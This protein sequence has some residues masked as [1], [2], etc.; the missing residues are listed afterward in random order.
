MKYFVN[1]ILHN[2]ETDGFDYQ[3]PA[4]FDNLDSAKKEFHN[5]LSTYINYGKLN[6]V[7][8]ILFD[9]YN[10]IY[11]KEVWEKPAPVVVIPDAIPDVEPE[12]E[13]EPIQTL[14]PIVED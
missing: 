8:A 7:S 14:D 3:R 9:D 2:E 13:G 10:N 4:S 1:R 11:M 5:V 12:E 6:K